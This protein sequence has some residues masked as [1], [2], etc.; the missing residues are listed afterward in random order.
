MSGRTFLYLGAPLGGLGLALASSN[1]HLAGGL[2]IA[3]GVLFVLA[4]FANVA[5]DF[6]AET[7]PRYMNL[8]LGLI[9]VCGIVVGAGL[10]LR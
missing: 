3:A 8:L 10:F 2:V 5:G 1:T 4:A 7:N 6:S 9:A